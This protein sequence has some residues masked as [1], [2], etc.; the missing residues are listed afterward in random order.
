MIDVSCPTVGRLEHEAVVPRPV[1]LLDTSTFQRCHIEMWFSLS[2]LRELGGALIQRWELFW[3]TLLWAE[4]Y[5][6]CLKLIQHSWGVNLNSKLLPFSFHC[7]VKQNHPSVPLSTLGVRPAPKIISLNAKR[8]R[9]TCSQ[10]KVEA[11]Y[12]QCQKMLKGTHSAAHLVCNNPSG[13]TM[14]YWRVTIS[15]LEWISTKKG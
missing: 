3:E 4:L 12:Q 9:G 13:S 15:A 6:S 1:S 14:I 11:H 2:R 8:G 7:S 10:G 5:H